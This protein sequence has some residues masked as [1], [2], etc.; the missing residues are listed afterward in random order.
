MNL[1]E[2]GDGTWESLG[3]GRE[4]GKDVIAEAKDVISK[5]KK[6][7]GGHHLFKVA[8]LNKPSVVMP[9]HNYVILRSLQNTGN[10][11]N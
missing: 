3:A 8:S 5:I 9:S 7:K 11:S 10:M 4:R 2:Q 1:K 6:C